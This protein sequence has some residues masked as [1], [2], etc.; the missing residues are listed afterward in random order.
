MVMSNMEVDVVDE[1]ALVLKFHLGATHIVP[2]VSP[3]CRP[4]AC[5]FE[6]VGSTLLQDVTLGL[7]WT[8]I[9]AHV[10]LHLCEIASGGR[11]THGRE[12]DNSTFRI[13]VY[14]HQISFAFDPVAQLVERQPRDPIDS[15]TRG[16]NPVRSTRTICKS[17]SVKMLC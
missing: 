10:V 7:S 8:S 2:E 13:P 15:M 16:S 4:H 11:P 6:C 17:F 5:F 14:H 1:L 12:V 9:P 3:R